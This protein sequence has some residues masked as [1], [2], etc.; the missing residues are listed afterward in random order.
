MGDCID[1]IPLTPAAKAEAEAVVETLFGKQPKAIDYDYIP[2][3]VF[4]RP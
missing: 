2:S 3:A 4:S 1:R